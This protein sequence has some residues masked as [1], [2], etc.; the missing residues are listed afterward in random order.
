MYASVF[1]TAYLALYD[2]EPN[3]Q[4]VCSKTEHSKWRTLQATLEKSHGNA[5]FSKAV[6]V[7]EPLDVLC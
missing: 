5:F 3:C 2:R 4:I 7:C 1:G 6:T